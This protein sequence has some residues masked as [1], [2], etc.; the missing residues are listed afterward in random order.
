VRQVELV[1]PEEPGVRV[2]PVDQ[3]ELADPEGPGVREVPVRRERSVFFLFFQS[4]PVSSLV[5]ITRSPSRLYHIKT[6][7]LVTFLGSP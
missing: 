7:G 5:L 2:E 1:D 4:F 3:V 6:C